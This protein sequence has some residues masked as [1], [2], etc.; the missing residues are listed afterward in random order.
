MER[1]SATSAKLRSAWMPPL[2][3]Q[4]PIVTKRREAL[5]TSW[6]RSASA[7]VVTEPSTSETS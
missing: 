2:V 7:V 6:M 5:R 3:A 4:A 1:Y